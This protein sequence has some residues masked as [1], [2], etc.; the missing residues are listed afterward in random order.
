MEG[1]L[2]Q[3]LPE[4][5]A[6]IIDEI[7]SIINE[8]L[9]VTNENAIIIASTDNK[10]V[11]DFHEG[12]KIAMKTERKYYITNEKSKMLRGVKPG[13][14]LPVYFEGSILGVIGITGIP[15]KVEPYA[16]I[17]RKMT[18]LLIKETYHIEQ[19]EWEIRGLESYLQEWIYTNRVD[20]KFIKRGQ[21]LGIPLGTPYHC[22]YV[23]VNVEPFIEKVKR[24]RAF[25][26]D[27]F[28]RKFSNN[29]Y[30]IRWGDGYFILVENKAE[31]NS[32][33]IL[34]RKLKE[35]KKYIEGNYHLKLAMGISKT[36]AGY[37][38]NKAYEEADKASKVAQKSSEIIFYEDLL[39]EMILEEINGDTR[40]EFINRVLNGIDNDK[41]LLSTLKVYLQHNQA[42]K[43][44]SAYM[45]IHIN[46]LHY[47]LRQ[48]KEI[49][50]IDP[51]ET[52][53][54]TLFNIVFS[55]LEN[56]FIYDDSLVNS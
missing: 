34:K 28:K 45:H 41:E 54:I 36:I 16:D 8:E 13:I 11:G 18:E 50:G 46:T 31:G 29:D 39:L 24:R 35:W 1:L 19:K 47:R 49:T 33:D 27:L 51:K 42:I 25:I 12:S 30:I 21:L 48:I 55:F 40:Q 14:N 32:T 6:K 7:R 15:D 20:E 10:R 52:K 43:D 38:I 44:T 22:I 26:I 5:A 17:I 2:L 23:R 37:Y 9:I 3:L 4:L 53:G 56:S